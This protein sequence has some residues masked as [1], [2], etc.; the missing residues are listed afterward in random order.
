MAK[1][2]QPNAPSNMQTG[3]FI[4]QDNKEIQMAYK[5]N[6]G[7]YKKMVNMIFAG[8]LRTLVKSQQRRFEDILDG[9]SCYSE[10]VMYKV[11][12]FLGESNTPI[13][14]F[15]LAN[16][17]EVDVINF[18]DTQV[19]FGQRYRYV[20]TAYN[21]V[22][23]STYVYSNL[24]STRRVTNKCVE[25]V[26][27]LSDKPV[28]PRVPGHI[29]KNNISGVRTALRCPSTKVVAEKT[30]GVPKCIHRRNAILRPLRQTY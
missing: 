27:A 25:F 15:W 12:K 8:K 6:H 23:G 21:L 16:T 29:I 11:E 10:E 20:A 1:A 26:D 24:S 3:I 17:N 7:F 30:Y 5:D 4:G 19:K 14:T 28:I 18:I 13:Q 22:I 2:V 9:D